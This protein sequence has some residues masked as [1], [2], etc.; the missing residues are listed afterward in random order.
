MTTRVLRPGDPVPVDDEW[1][2]RTLEERIEAVWMLTKICYAWAEDA[3]GEPRLQRSVV[4]VQR[5]WR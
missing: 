2:T 3:A 1:L 4:R 5:L